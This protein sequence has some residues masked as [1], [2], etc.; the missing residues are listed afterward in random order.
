MT[1]TQMRKVFIHTTDEFQYVVPIEMKDEFY[2]LLLQ[3]YNN[4]TEENKDVFLNKFS[5][6]Q[7]TNKPPALEVYVPE[8]G[9]YDK[10]RD[11]E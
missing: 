5:C 2:H 7:C 9:L 6:Y 8:R 11:K 10:R 1:I 3:F 4:K